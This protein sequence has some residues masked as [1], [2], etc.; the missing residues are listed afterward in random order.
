M[1]QV[2]FF[3]IWD[4]NLANPDLE[5]KMGPEPIVINGVITPINGLTEWVS[6]ASF[7]P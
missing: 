7:N 2:F 3:D 6:L 4:M 5:V 1:T